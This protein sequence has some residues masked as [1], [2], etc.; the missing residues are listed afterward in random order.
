MGL[1]A[2]AAG[3]DSDLQC[4]MCHLSQPEMHCALVAV[5]ATVSYDCRQRSPATELLFGASVHSPEQLHIK[6]SWH[7]P[8]QPA[9]MF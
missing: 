3:L 7:V 2:F 5:A 1:D 4:S 8:S 9:C 6:Q